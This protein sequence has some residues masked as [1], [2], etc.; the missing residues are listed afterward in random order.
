MRLDFVTVDLPLGHQR[1][2]YSDDVQLH[3]LWIFQLPGND[4]LA[5]LDWQEID[6]DKDFYS[7]ALGWAELV[8]RDIVRQELID[9]SSAMLQQFDFTAH[10]S[11]AQLQK[12]LVRHYVFGICTVLLTFSVDYRLKSD[13]LPKIG[14]LFDD[15]SMAVCDGLRAVLGLAKNTRM[16]KVW[17]SCVVTSLGEPDVAKQIGDKVS[18]FTEV[19]RLSD[20][21][22]ISNSLVGNKFSIFN[23]TSQERLYDCM[24]LFNRA[25]AYAAGMYR[26]ERLTL[27]ELAFLTSRGRLKERQLEESRM[28]HNG[29]RMLRA[30]WVHQLIAAPVNRREVQEKLWKLWSMELL[31]NGTSEVSEKI[32]SILTARS[33]QRRNLLGSRLN[34]IVLSAAIVQVV[35]AIIALSG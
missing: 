18:G 19:A 23:A 30:L 31:V 22:G 8:A 35:V 9:E 28:T 13:D 25:H 15:H 6:V 3:G 10:L 21:D 7:D 11:D 14:S 5:N 4:E 20:L 26:Y 34:W 16:A 12:V 1:V 29:V 17:G 2:S 27:R 24:E 32:S 33:D